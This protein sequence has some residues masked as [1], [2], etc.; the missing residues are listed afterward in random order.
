MISR[1]SLVA[2]MP[3]RIK[4]ARKSIFRSIGVGSRPRMVRQNHHPSV[5]ARRAKRHNC[6]CGDCEGLKGG[7]SGSC[8]NCRCAQGQQSTGGVA[9]QKYGDVLVS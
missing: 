7:G 3:V 2:K 8:R 1:N 6:P 9:G 5:S 4:A